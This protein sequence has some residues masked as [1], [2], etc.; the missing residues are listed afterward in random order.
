MKFQTAATLALL[1]TTAPLAQG[2]TQEPRI[3]DRGVE[4]LDP[5]AASLR[6]IDMGIDAITNRARL[7]DLTDDHRDDQRLPVQ[8][9]GGYVMEAAGFT[10]VLGQMDYLVRT[11]DGF[12]HNVAGVDGVERVSLIAP[13]SYF[14]LIPDTS[15]PIRNDPFRPGQLDLRL[16]AS[17]NLAPAVAP[18]ALDRSEFGITPIA[19]TPLFQ[20]AFRPFEADETP[21][22]GW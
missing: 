12:T 17:Y 22:G 1:M 20:E 11:R 9:Q 15:E 19:A 10:A 2:Q 8:P 13:N 7:F 5:N 16:D 14:S 21:P 18:V 6:R 4:D 3:I